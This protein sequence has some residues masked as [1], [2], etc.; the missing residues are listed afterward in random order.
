MRTYA[1]IGKTSVH[2]AYGFRSFCEVHVH[3]QGFRTRI[4]SGKKMEEYLAKHPRIKAAAEKE[5][6]AAWAEGREWREK[7]KFVTYDADRGSLRVRVGGAN[8]DI[9]NGY[10]DVLGAKVYII[11]EGGVMPPEFRFV[12]SVEGKVEIMDYDCDPAHVAATVT[13]PSFYRGEGGRFV[14][15]SKD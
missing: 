6:E 14:V 11:G 12:L 4:L 7:T 10:G 15:Q 5:M 13:D 1:Q 8:V 3:G 2:F 9:H